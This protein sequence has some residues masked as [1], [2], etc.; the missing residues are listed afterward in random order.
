MPANSRNLDDLHY[1][2]NAGAADN[3][4]HH[5]AYDPHDHRHEDKRRNRERQRLTCRQGPR[6]VH[7]L[8]RSM[9]SHAP[10]HSRGRP[11]PPPR[12]TLDSSDFN[13]T[14]THSLAQLSP[15]PPVPRLQGDLRCVFVPSLLL[16]VPLVGLA[17]CSGSAASPV[18]PNPGTSAADFGRT[19]FGSADD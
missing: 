15:L 13:T 7:R 11:H 1:H 18:S 14:S 17:A 19:D 12:A 8:K 16:T 6:G 10:H 3:H 4:D 2:D 9:T 5:N